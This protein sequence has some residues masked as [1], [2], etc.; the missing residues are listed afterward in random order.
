MDISRDLYQQ[1][2]KA[3]VEGPADLEFALE[4]FGVMKNA[5]IQDTAELQRRFS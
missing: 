1:F 2:K 4:A 3:G 5:G